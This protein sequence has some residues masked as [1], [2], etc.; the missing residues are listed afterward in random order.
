MGM[1]DPVTMIPARV[2][3]CLDMIDSIIDFAKD[4]DV[5]LI[6]FAGDAFHRYNPNPLYMSEFAKRVVAMRK[7]CPVVLLVGNHDLSPKTSSVEIYQSLQL[8]GIVVGNT[9]A[10]HKIQTKSGIVQVATAP[11]PTKQQRPTFLDAIFNLGD[12]ITDEGLAILVGHFTVSGSQL[13][14]ERGFMLGVDAEVPLELLSDEV[15]DYVALGHIHYHQCLNEHPPV[16]YS[17]APDRVTFNEEKDAKGFV[18]IETVNDNLTWEFI[19]LDARP[20][21]TVEVSTLKSDPMP[22]I[23]AAIESADL[24]RAVVRILIKVKERFVKLV[25]RKAIMALLDK[26]GMFS[27]SS[28]VISNIKAERD[29]RIDPEKFNITKTHGELLV[30]YF[31]NTGITGKE[32]A[33]AMKTAGNI[34]DEVDSNDS[35][36]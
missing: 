11:Y 19:E 27:L 2:L 25:D 28:L 7:Q 13:G 15:W 5:D 29:E 18:F 6:I 1:I 20:Y 14:S 4:E 3:D 32:L 16:V 17:G 30:A 22:K 23:I 26:S 9:Y 8:D 12:E 33:Q 34:M 35:L 31:E 10:V 36:K 21:V 24:S